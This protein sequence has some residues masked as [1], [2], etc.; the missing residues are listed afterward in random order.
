MPRATPNSRFA[1]TAIA[2]AVNVSVSAAIASGSVIAVRYASHPSR[3][4]S[5]NTAASGTARKRKR[6]PNAVAVNSQRTGRRLGEPLLRIARSAGLYVCHQ[7]ASF[8]LLQP[9]S[10]LTVSRSVNEISSMTTAMAVA[11]A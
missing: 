7:C 11:P 5:V 8:R 10:A 6:N 3:N 9:C 1:G 4:A 2:A